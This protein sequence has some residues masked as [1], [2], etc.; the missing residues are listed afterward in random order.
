MHFGNTYYFVELDRFKMEDDYKELNKTSV[1][2]RDWIKEILQE[3][4]EFREKRFKTEK[5]A[6]AHLEKLK[7]KYKGTPYVGYLF[8]SEGCGVYF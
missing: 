8:Q 5:Q 2:L 1:G 7:K 6:K 4:P 3:Y